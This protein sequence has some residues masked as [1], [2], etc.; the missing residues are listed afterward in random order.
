M[1]AAMSLSLV[2]IRQR[3]SQERPLGAWKGQRRVL[4]VLGLLSPTPKARLL[5]H[6]RGW[7]P[8]LPSR[9]FRAEAHSGALYLGQRGLAI[10]SL[11]VQ[12][13]RRRRDWEAAGH[14][15]ACTTSMCASISLND[16]GTG[17]SL[18]AEARAG[19]D[20]VPHASCTAGEQNE[21][22]CL[23]LLTIEASQY[24]SGQD[25]VSTNNEKV[26]F[27]EGYHAT[28]WA[29]NFLQCAQK[30]GFEC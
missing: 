11:G 2:Y 30:R 26:R 8:P 14:V 15:S 4:S 22:G 25:P 21:R 24:S 20:R 3:G 16:R 29:S 1:M 13:G 28:P 12:G 10:G 17:H 7:L 19:S 18:P 9:R 5:A 6:I 23:D 27:I